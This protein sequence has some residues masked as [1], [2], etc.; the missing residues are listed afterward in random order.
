MVV[1]D[2]LIVCAQNNFSPEPETGRHDGG[3]GLVLRRGREGLEVVPARR[4]GITIFGDCRNLLA[5][6]GS[7]PAAILFGVNN[8]RVRTFR[9][10]QG[11]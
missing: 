11:N 2:D 7:D 3:T 9:R 6:P 10:S 1:V 5:L 4:H 8:D